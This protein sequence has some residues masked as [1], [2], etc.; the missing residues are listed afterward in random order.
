M[1]GPLSVAGRSSRGAFWASPGW[2]WR[3]APFAGLLAALLAASPMTQ[4]DEAA[5]A[6]PAA[7]AAAG[8]ALAGIPL[9]TLSATRDRPLFLPA[10]RRPAPPPAQVALEPAP[11]PPLPVAQEPPP[12]LTLLGIIRSRKTGGAAV[13]L[14]ET[15]HTSLSL[16]PGDD[17]HGWVVQ[18]IDGNIVTL[19]NGERVVRLTYPEPANRSGPGAMPNADDE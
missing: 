18:A 12:R 10:R 16:K 4:A 5:P 17:R 3:T 19:K 2:P 7:S 1:R 15:D 11:P 9:A 14:D 13:V 8:G 6:D